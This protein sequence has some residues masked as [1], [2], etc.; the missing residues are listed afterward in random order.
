MVLRPWTRNCNSLL[1]IVT[2]VIR[3]G[4]GNPSGRM[5]VS[6]TITFKG[7]PLEHGQ[8]SFRPTGGS[9]L[10]SGSAIED[11]KFAI[12]GKKGLPVGKYIVQI[13]SGDYEL[14]AKQ[15]IGLRVPLPLPERIPVDWSGDS[16]HE[17][18]I[19]DG[20]NNLHFEIP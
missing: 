17:I 18:E 5:P 19:V 16:K 12:P 2:L 13:S 11:G 4:C 10:S 7:K 20:E 9:H 15:N 8:I 6:G 1:A 14:G 3:C